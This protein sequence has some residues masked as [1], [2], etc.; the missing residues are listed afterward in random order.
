MCLHLEDNPTYPL[1]CDQEKTLPGMLST[2]DYVILQSLFSGADCGHSR[3]SCASQ[4]PGLFSLSFVSRPRD[5]LGWPGLEQH[6]LM[7]DSRSPR[8]ILRLAL[9]SF[10]TSKWRNLEALVEQWDGRMK[11]RASDSGHLNSRGS[12]QATPPLWALFCL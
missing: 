6:L 7:K 11:G 5:L 8:P 1:R 4:F 12:G 2:T 10:M 3:G 9:A